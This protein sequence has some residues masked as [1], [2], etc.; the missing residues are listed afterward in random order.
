MDNTFVV[1]AVRACLGGEA[2]LVGGAVRDSLIGAKRSI[3][4][5]DFATPLQVNEVIRLMEENGY[6][7][8]THSAKYG[9][10]SAK[11]AQT[12][13]EI[14]TFRSDS[15]EDSSDEPTIDF[16]TSIIDDLKRRDFTINAIAH[17]GKSYID[18]FD[19]QSDIIG[20]KIKAVGNAALRFEEDPL[21]ILRALRFVSEL[22][23]TLSP[24]TYD[25]MANSGDLIG[26]ISRERITAECD[27]I[28]CGEYWIQALSLSIET[29]VFDT[30]FGI[31][32][33]EEFIDK[34][35]TNLQKAKD[36]P[37]N[38]VSRWKVL[39]DS[40]VH[41][42]ASD[43]SGKSQ[44]KILHE[45][46]EKLRENLKWRVSFA[47][48][49][50]DK[51]ADNL[52]EESLQKLE[53]DY[54][55]FSSKNDNK[56]YIV[57]EKIIG[58]KVRQAV[59]ER[60]LNEAANYAVKLI[61]VQNTNLQIRVNR[62][63]DH[64][65][66]IKDSKPFLLESVRYILLRKIEQYGYFDTREQLNDLIT[67]LLKSKQTF[68]LL[69]F[70]VGIED[71]LRIIE[72][73]V[74]IANRILSGRVTS[75]T[76]AEIFDQNSHIKRSSRRLAKIK[77]SYI[78]ELIAL[79]KP[80]YRDDVI[81][82]R[83]QLNYK[84]AK[85]ILELEGQPSLGYFS[86]LVDHYKWKSFLSTD[87]EV[88]WQTYDQMNTMLDFIYE[89]P[90]F[91]ESYSE[92]SQFL[93]NA[94]CLTFAV[95]LVTDI[96]DKISLVRNII[97][98]YKFARH[99]SARNVHRYTLL[100][101]WLNICKELIGNP[102]EFSSSILLKFPLLKSYHYNDIDEDYIA[103]K[104]PEIDK[105][106]TNFYDIEAFLSLLNNV[107]TA[108]K[109]RNTALNSII[110]FKRD[111]YIDFELAYE[112]FKNVLRS[113]I[114]ESAPLEPISLLKDTDDSEVLSE[115][116]QESLALIKQ[117]E[118]EI[119]E[120]KESWRYDVRKKEINPQ[121]LD[122][123]MRTIVSFMNTKGGTLFI[124]VHDS[125]DIIGLEKSDFIQFK[126]KGLN[127]LGLQDSLKKIIDDQLR[128]IVGA[129]AATLVKVSFELFDEKTIGVLYVEP[130]LKD[131]FLDNKYYVRYSASCRELSI[132]EY[133]EYISIRK[134]PIN[135]LA[136]NEYLN[137]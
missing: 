115:K 27:K 59:S 38:T 119:V 129:V 128:K 50:F 39:I 110:S 11:I 14:S 105:V 79:R 74:L 1:E 48:S 106:R 41:T 117:G 26:N 10:V 62:G 84:V 13:V 37:N 118:S 6:K 23:F 71:K 49:L 73:A 18:P 68:N 69:S 3:K 116:A 56:Q 8:V 66:A 136:E 94:Q 82:R 125:G 72:E 77:Y 65:E 21:R 5:Y 75:L 80:P 45:V 70:E 76:D 92:S 36:T 25:A 17:N 123:T 22:G 86:H 33:S 108:V 134:T 91:H 111:S 42:L 15:Y 40:L 131:V 112:I 126:K 30:I 32:L 60:M 46:F 127:Q 2:Y 4:D 122:S 78:R 103:Q 81:E 124:G 132:K 104:M 16:L 43:H 55:S 67:K 101:E 113:L 120:F 90:K 44:G 53:K 98:N 24:E 61:E 47:Q 9:T 54:A 87:P 107:D 100:I 34:F 29:G 64:G 52:I 57:S 63:Y 88:F 83:A 19:G 35:L 95:T 31:S 58:I 7:V 130:S 97:A 114:H 121:L 93:Y 99:K 89:N 20:R 102:A 133:S 85:V 135:L 51:L 137:V 96:E 109:I 12:K 28:I